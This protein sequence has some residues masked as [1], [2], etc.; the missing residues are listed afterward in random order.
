MDVVLA[1][2]IPGLTLEESI[3]Y[4]KVSGGKPLW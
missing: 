3:A 2:Q 1:D 4:G